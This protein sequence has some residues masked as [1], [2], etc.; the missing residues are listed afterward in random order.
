M[1]LAVDLQAT[2]KAQALL[3]KSRHVVTHIESVPWRDV[4]DFYASL[5]E[6][7]IT[8][9][10]LRLLILTAGTRSKPLRFLRRSD[11][12]DGVWKIAGE[13]MKGLKGKTADFTVPLSHEA[14]KIIN[15]AMPFERDGFLFPS[16]RKGV[17]SDATM[18]R[19]MERRGMAARPHGFRSSFRTWLD[20]AT[21]YPFELK[22]ACMAH[23]VGNAVS[24]SYIR[25]D[26]I[27]KRRE[28]TYPV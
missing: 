20:E 4:P 3:G 11:I 1:G 22:E 16:M 8:H 24:R 17:I 26:N 13:D 12:A 9:L 5:E 18:A 28:M 7:S 14:S 27:D 21:D 2:E 10:A 15:L 23:S 19:L 6:P 25:T